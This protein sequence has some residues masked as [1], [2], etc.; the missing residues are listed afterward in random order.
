MD[1]CT[2]NDFREALAAP[3][4]HFRTLDGIK[5]DLTTLCRTTHFAECRVTYRNHDA[6]LYVPITPRAMEFALCANKSL[7]PTRGSN[8]CPMMILCAEM[9]CHSTTNQSCSVIVEDI[10]K[11][12][13]LKRAMT[14]A[15]SIILAEGIR[16]LEALLKFYDISHNNLT[17]ENLM[18]DIY[19]KVY[20]IRQYYTTSG[21]GGD[22]MALSR[23]L[24]EIESLAPCGCAGED[25]SSYRV[26]QIKAERL[27]ESRRLFRTSQGMG[28]KDEGGKVVI[29][30]KYSWAT[31]FYEGRAIVG[32]DRNKFGVIDRNGNA[33]VPIIY[34]HI[35]FNRTT[36]GIRAYIDNRMAEFN[37]SGEQTS[38]WKA[39]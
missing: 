35:E 5:S 19:G 4:H 37:Y 25:L 29:E 39:P 14:A 28:Y 11:L 7:Y 27:N 12:T 3:E 32:N 13:P 6:M 8:L 10:T 22:N 31:E 21:C 24:A 26:E 20:P 18:I 17:I 33:I 1:I 15:N 23:T 16:E 38:E 36:C 34:D 9:T 2:I 30:A